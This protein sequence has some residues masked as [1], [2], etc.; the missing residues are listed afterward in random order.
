MKFIEK[1]PPRIFTTGTKGRSPISDCGEVYLNPDE[2]ITFVT[3]SGKNYDF[4]AKDWGYYAT[5]SI[6]G[7]LARE[8]F[9]TAIVKNQGGKYFI[10]VVDKDSL[11]DFEAYLSTENST[12]IDW[13]DEY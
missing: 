4:V 7:R 2:Q 8:G 11:A 13:L 1:N 6:N 3:A 5:P 10:M 12:T 9:K